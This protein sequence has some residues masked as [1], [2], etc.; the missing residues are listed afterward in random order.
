MKNWIS[1]SC[2]L[3]G[4]IAFEAKAQPGVGC[5]RASDELLY[6]QKNGFGYYELLGNRYPISPPSCPRVQLG[7]KT[8]SKCQF[9]ALGTQHDEYNYVLYT[10]TGPVQ[11]DLD[12]YSY[13][14]LAIAGFFAVMRMRSHK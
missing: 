10:A 13:G 5:F 7:T 6:S 14:A 9:V 2:L 11:C 12:H 4:L 1:L 3:I 8:G